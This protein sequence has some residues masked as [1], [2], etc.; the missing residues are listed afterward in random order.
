MHFAADQQQ[1]TIKGRY[2]RQQ[3][4]LTTSI[5]EANK[6]AIAAK[7]KEMREFREDETGWEDKYRVTAAEIERRMREISRAKGEL[8]DLKRREWAEVMEACKEY[9]EVWRPL[10]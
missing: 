10:G 4:V 2:F 1:E 3:Q 5:A 6:A 8:G 7:E 9:D